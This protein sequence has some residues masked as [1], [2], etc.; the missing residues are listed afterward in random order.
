MKYGPF[1]ILLSPE[2]LAV[3]TLHCA[4]MAM[5]R[6]ELQKKKALGSRKLRST[7]G[8]CILSGLSATIGRVRCHA[9]FCRPQIPTPKYPR[10]CL[11]A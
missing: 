3:I 4:V 8:Q 5:M 10:S 11:S 2:Q 9:H 7:G 1:L 6:G